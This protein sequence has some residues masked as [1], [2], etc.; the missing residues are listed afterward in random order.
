MPTPGPRQREARKLEQRD[1][2]WIDRITGKILDDVDAH[3]EARD[4][5]GGDAQLLVL[6]D[7]DPARVPVVPGAAANAD[8]PTDESSKTVPG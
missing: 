3:V 8:R 4:E 7:D 5:V 1:A 6:D 2:V